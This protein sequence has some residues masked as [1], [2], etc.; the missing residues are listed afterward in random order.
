M[1]MKLSQR[2]LLQNENVLGGCADSKVRELTKQL[3]DKKGKQKRLNKITNSHG[4]PQTNVRTQ[5]GGKKESPS[6]RESL[7]YRKRTSFRPS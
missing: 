3:V 4:N 7:K 2:E 5:G 1:V 6:G